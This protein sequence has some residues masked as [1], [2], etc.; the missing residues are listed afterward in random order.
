M[1]PGDTSGH[2]GGGGMDPDSMG[3]HH[4]PGP[5]IIGQ[6]GIPYKILQGSSGNVDDRSNPGRVIIESKEGEKLE[7]PRR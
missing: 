1:D 3:G 2:H 4:G 7:A 5:G 6:D